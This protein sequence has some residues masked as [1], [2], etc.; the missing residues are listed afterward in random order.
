M[1]MTTVQ[2]P[3]VHGGCLCRSIAPGA[4]SKDIFYK[5]KELLA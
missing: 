1:A 3:G 5:N 2:Y 4:L